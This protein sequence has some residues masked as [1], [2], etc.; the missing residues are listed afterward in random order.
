MLDIAPTPDRRGVVGVAARD[1]RLLL[2]RRSRTVV[3]PGMYCFPGGGVEGD[4]SEPQAL[5]REF[6]E[7]LD[8]AIEPLRLLWRSV[9][10]WHVQLSWWLVDMA[11]DAEPVPNPVEVESIH[12][13]TPAEM[14]ALPDSLPS[15]F[16]FLDALAAG[17]IV[18]GGV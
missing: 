6:R 5:V 14:A 4:E 16:E 18:L 1:G 15:N 10:P 11:V 8:V 13:L 7:E 12:W 9:T 17:R 2:I 3:A